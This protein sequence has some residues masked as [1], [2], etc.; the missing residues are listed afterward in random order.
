[1]NIFVAKLHYDTT[2]EDLQEV[3]GA[4]GEVDSAKVIFDRETGMS[5]GFGF[6]EMPNDAEGF[7][8]IEGLNET[9]LNGRT[10]VV[11]KAK[12]REEYNNQSRRPSFRERF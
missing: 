1:M 8:A 9:E 11:K 4:Y 5:R 2:S 7:K 3:F 6:V 10:I 12:P